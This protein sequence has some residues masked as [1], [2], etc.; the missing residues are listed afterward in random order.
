MSRIGT[1]RFTGRLGGWSSRA[2][3]RMSDRGSLLPE[4]LNAPVEWVPCVPNGSEATVPD[5]GEVRV[6][7]GCVAHGTGPRR[8][9]PIRPIGP[10]RCRRGLRPPTRSDLSPVRSGRGT[11][12]DPVGIERRTEARPT[13]DPGSGMC[14]MH[15]KRTLAVRSISTQ[16]GRP[17]VARWCRFLVGLRDRLPA[18]AATAT[19]SWSGSGRIMQESSC[20]SGSSSATGGAQCPVGGLPRGMMRTTILAAGAIAGVA[21]DRCGQWPDPEPS[22]QDCSD[23]PGAAG[24]RKACSGRHR[25]PPPATA[26]PPI[27][28]R[29]G[30]R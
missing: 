27:P 23:P 21:P 3:C 7:D 29:P 5:P 15:A 30:T 17:D 6:R 20:M 8:P 24:C 1:L 19:T 10:V 22:E 26:R 18:V 11:T 16:S 13:Q 14:A 12:K 9:G 28:S 25:P 4:S 2:S